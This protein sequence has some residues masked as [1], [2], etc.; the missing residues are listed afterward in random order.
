[1]REKEAESGGS[2]RYVKS[3]FFALACHPPKGAKE[4]RRVLCLNPVPFDAF[5]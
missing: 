2:P 3:P 5:G 4:I 1:M